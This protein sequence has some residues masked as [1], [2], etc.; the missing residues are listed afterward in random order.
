[1]NWFFIA[2]GAP[3]LWAVTNHIDKLLLDKYFKRCGVSTLIVFSAFAGVLTLPFLY[4]IDPRVFSVA[5]LHIALLLVV[6]LC[7]ATSFFLYFH[8][9]D[10][11]EASIVVVFYQ[12]I[13]IFG[14]LFGY[15][16]LHEALGLMKLVAMGVILAGALI[17]SIEVDEENRFRLKHR[18]IYLMSAASVLVAAEA[19]LF[20]YVAVQESVWTSLFWQYV[21]MGVFALATYALVGSCRAEIASVI[22]RNT[23]GTLLINIVN[24]LI[25]LLG[26]FLFSYAY[27]LAPV[28]LVLTVNA[29]QPLLVFIIGMV[30]TVLFPHLG[31]ESI[32]LRHVMQKVLAM[33]IVGLGTWLLFV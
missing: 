7:T 9:L 15:I 17:V 23:A 25:F 29:Y 5:P 13:P 1:M 21:G 18:T 4:L 11:E 28:A 20:K 33:G 19:V 16:L 27:L 10:G 2:L 22:R 12:L 26:N 24:E 14:Y 30:L 6:S 8:A 32:K 3:F 31:T